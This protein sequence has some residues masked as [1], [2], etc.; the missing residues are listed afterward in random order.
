MTMS[1]LSL[2]PTHLN[3]IESGHGRSLP[4]KLEEAK[5][6]LNPDGTLVR[7]EPGSWFV[8]FVPA[9]TK[10]WWQ[11]LLHP[12]HTHVF[13]IRPEGDGGWTVF[14]PSWTRL[15]VAT[16]TT[17]QAIKFLVWG[18]KGDVLLVREESPGHSSQ[19][20][21]MMT[22]AA[23]A[24]HMLGKNYI[25]WTPHQLYRRL[26][27]EP[28]VCKVDVSILLQGDI[29]KL[30]G[31]NSRIVEACDDCKAGQP[32]RPPGVQKPFCMKCGRGY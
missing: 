31:K 30:A 32:N 14:E 11:G 3:R 18:A 15:L 29:R 17:E 25:V 12:M 10:E 6:S 13:S 1:R 26:I 22:C 23:L 5:L 7:L 27:R 21:G 16:I 8:C 19:L 28:R 24:A 2:R 4:A 9:I 20:R